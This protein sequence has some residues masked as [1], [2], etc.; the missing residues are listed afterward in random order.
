MEAWI[1]R[2]STS[3]ARQTLQE[4]RMNSNLHNSIKRGR[5]CAGMTS[6]TSRWDA[7]GG[8]TPKGDGEAPKGRG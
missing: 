6:H 1:C 2:P 4:S 3:H 5:R 7:Q 8:L